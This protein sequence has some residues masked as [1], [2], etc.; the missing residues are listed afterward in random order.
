MKLATQLHLAPRL[1]AVEVYLHYPHHDMLVNEVRKSFAFCWS[2]MSSV[3]AF[4]VK[5]RTESNNICTCLAFHNFVTIYMGGKIRKRCH[6]F[7]RLQDLIAYLL[8]HFFSLATNLNE[9][10]SFVKLGVQCAYTRLLG[11]V[12]RKL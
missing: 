5:S 6:K 12:I 8:A 4:C 2:I 1:R 10:Q 9:S 3:I 11:Y 7:P